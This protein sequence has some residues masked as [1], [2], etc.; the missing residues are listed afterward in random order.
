MRLHTQRKANPNTPKTAQPPYNDNSTCGLA[1]YNVPDANAPTPMPTSSAI[2]MVP[3]AVA[4]FPSGAK[5]T[6]HAKMVG[7]L[8][9]TDNP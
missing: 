5:S 3:K 1:A 8:I 9:P 2:N 7:M 4:A 6:V